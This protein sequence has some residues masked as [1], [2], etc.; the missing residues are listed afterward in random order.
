MPQHRK[1]TALKMLAGNPGKRPLPANEP[2]PT[3]GLPPCPDWMP[4]DG[5]RQW[6]TIVPELERLG[7]LASVDVAVVETFCALYA[8][9][10]ETARAGKPV[11]TN[12]VSAMRMYAM[13][14]GLTPA[15]RSKVSAPGAQ[16]EAAEEEFFRPAL[17]R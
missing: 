5:R 12:V 6:Q 13:E 7:V 11:K 3:L 8:D 9:V 4:E 14:L 17:V 15:S 2:K 1:P 16:H 10:V